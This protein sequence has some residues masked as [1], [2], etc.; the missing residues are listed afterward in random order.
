M[1]RPSATTARYRFSP[2]SPD[3]GEP[4]GRR[5]RAL[6]ANE[7][8]LAA[9][10]G[11]VRAFLSADRA[12]FSWQPTIDAWLSSWDEAFSARLGDAGFL[13]LTIPRDYGFRRR[14]L[15]TGH[16]VGDGFE[17]VDDLRDGGTRGG[18]DAGDRLDP[19]SD[20]H[21]AERLAGQ[22][23][24]GVNVAGQKR[25]AD[26]GRDKLLDNSEVVDSLNDSGM[27]PG[28]GG[29]GPQDV[30]DHQSALDADPG[31]VGQFTQR[32]ARAA[33]QPMMLRQCDFERFAQ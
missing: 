32:D 21:S 5:L 22:L 26:P 9:L 11:E 14:V 25:D 30:V 1:R 7:P 6:C 15:L 18:S 33:G 28:D 27:D 23:A 31:L 4:R 2:A 19:A 29:Q 12:E 17:D 10:R 13:G 24:C 20:T 3:T 8:E 16:V